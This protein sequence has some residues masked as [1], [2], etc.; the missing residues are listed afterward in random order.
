MISNL[1]FRLL[2]FFKTISKWKYS[3]DTYL[4]VMRKSLLI[5]ALRSKLNGLKST[6]IKGINNK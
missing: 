4:E 6:Q 1:E 2:I 3:V 5:C